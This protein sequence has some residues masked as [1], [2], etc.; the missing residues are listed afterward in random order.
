[1]R[2]SA[3]L[4]PILDPAALAPLE[5][6]RVA[7]LLAEAG[8]E[9]IQLRD[10][11]P[12]DQDRYQRARAVM[13]AVAPT[14]TRL[15][16]N[17]RADLAALVGAG[18]LHLGQDDLPPRRARAVVGARVLVGQSTGRAA[19]ARVAGGDECVDV[20]AIGPVFRSANRARAAAPIG[21][22]GVAAAR[23]ATT[24]PL[25]AIGGIDASN[26]AEVIAAGAD[27][28]AVI[29]ALTRGSYGAIEGALAQ[30]LAACGRVAEE[31]RR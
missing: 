15:W 22:E 23:R 1:M 7:S 31:E 19:H 29:G 9:W 28:V 4:Y 20:V 10:K 16:I 24:K 25:V 26:A 18:G 27:R 17:D 6:Q 21:L 12:S 2:A 13:G 3:R 8:I 5:P 30:L 11:A 14:S